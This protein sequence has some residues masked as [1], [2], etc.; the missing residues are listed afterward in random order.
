VLYAHFHTVDSVVNKVVHGVTRVLYRMFDTRGLRIVDSIMDAEAVSEILLNRGVTHLI[1][2]EHDTLSS[3]PKFQT[4]AR[5]RGVVIPGVEFTT[6]FGHLL[7]IGGGLQLQE[8]TDISD[9]FMRLDPERAA[10]RELFMNLYWELVGKGLLVQAAHPYDFRDFWHGPSIPVELHNCAVSKQPLDSKDSEFV[11][12]RTGQ[13]ASIVGNDAHGYDQLNRGVN[14]TIILG[15]TSAETVIEDMLAGRVQIIHIVEKFPRWQVI[16]PVIWRLPRM[17]GE[18][19]KAN[20][21]S[22]A[23]LVQILLL[24]ELNTRQLVTLRRA[25]LAG[26]F[27]ALLSGILLSDRY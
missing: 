4:A 23:E 12:S 20:E 14:F 18:Q 19:A 25:A 26:V 16:P 27:A 2:T 21:L 17:L 22:F 7:V 13:R 5:Q 11:P 15:A 8:I 1:P 10:D 9:R 3:L 24:P 6:P